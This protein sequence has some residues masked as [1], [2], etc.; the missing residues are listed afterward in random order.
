MSAKSSLI[1][2]SQAILVS[3]ASEKGEPA[4][5][6]FILASHAVNQILFYPRIQGLLGQFVANLNHHFTSLPM[7]E[8]RVG[9]YSNK[10]IFQFI[11]LTQ[12]LENFLLCGRYIT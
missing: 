8:Y 9:R 4:K 6:N 5:N 11:L 10:V 12:R 2:L 1:L 3:L 7:H